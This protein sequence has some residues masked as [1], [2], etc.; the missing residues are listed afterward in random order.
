MRPNGRKSIQQTKRRV[1]L[2]MYLSNACLET[3]SRTLACARI[4]VQTQ[5]KSNLTSTFPNVYRY[6]EISHAFFFM[7]ITNNF[8]LPTYFF[9][10]HQNYTKNTHICLSNCQIYWSNI[11]KE[12]NFI[13]CFVINQQAHQNFWS[14]N[15]A[16][17]VN[18]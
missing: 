1:I 2:I 15:S 10:I 7:W 17:A 4:Y 8:S 13:F 3:W 16:R 14:Y 5:N 12:E 9:L 18:P 11:Y 6:Y